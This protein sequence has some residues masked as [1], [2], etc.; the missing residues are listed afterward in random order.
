[1]RVITGAGVLLV[2]TIGALL[3]VEIEIKQILL[4][5]F[6]ESFENGRRNFAIG[7][8]SFQVGVHIISAFFDMIDEIIKRVESLTLENTVFGR[9]AVHSFFLVLDSGFFLG[10]IQD[11]FFHRGGHG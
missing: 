1:M 11:F 9:Q 6:E 10:N 8:N 3:E 7:K 4:E 5:E 2:G